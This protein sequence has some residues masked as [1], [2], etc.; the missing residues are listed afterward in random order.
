MKI[1]GPQNAAGH[2]LKRASRGGGH[3]WRLIIG[4]IQDIPPPL[5]PQTRYGQTTPFNPPERS[6]DV[7]NSLKTRASV[8]RS[9]Q[10][11][12]VLAL[13]R[14]LYVSKDTSGY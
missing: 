12:D 7:Q 14:D 3:R 10:N 8:R 9:E 6:V 11:T 4:D 1:V 5:Y 2:I 13:N